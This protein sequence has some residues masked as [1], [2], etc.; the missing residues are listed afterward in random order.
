MSFAPYPLEMSATT[1]TNDCP[2]VTIKHSGYFYASCEKYSR[3][4]FLIRKYLPFVGQMLSIT[5]TVVGIILFMDSS[6]ITCPKLR[7]IFYVQAQLF[8]LQ[9]CI[10]NLFIGFI[11]GHSD[12]IL[13]W[14]LNIL[15][16]LSVMYRSP[17]KIRGYA[18]FTWMKTHLHRA[19]KFRARS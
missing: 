18:A 10:C 17:M 11:R 13:S 4:P 6:N 1:P 9:I 3:V 12:I 15:S 7:F 8:Y 19:L 14:I 5:T 16:K 2:S